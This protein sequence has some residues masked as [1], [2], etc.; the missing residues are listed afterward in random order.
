M[1]REESRL[2]DVAALYVSEIALNWTEE[3]QESANRTLHSFISGQ[4]DFP[5]A[6]AMFQREFHTTV[7][8]ER[9]N[10]ILTVPDMPL[11]SSALCA[12]DG[13]RRKTH[14]WTPPEDIRLLAALHKFGGDNWSRIAKFVGSD[15]TRSQCS[16][17]WQRGLDPRISR[18]HW[19]KEEEDLLVELVAKHGTKSWIAV[20]REMRNRSDVQ[21]R[22]RYMQLHTASP[23][24]PPLLP[25]MPQ[26]PFPRLGEP[27]STTVAN[28][29]DTVLWDNDETLRMK[30]SCSIWQ[31][32][33][34]HSDYRWTID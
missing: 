21:C 6:S 25:P 22:Y 5:T 32:E 19:T 12:T 2:F 27:L 30:T 26:I 17:R 18:S 9:I 20:S 7:P 31:N 28:V 4:I 16:Q 8:V 13:F 29:F 34:G 1:S 10:E 11:P 24:S 33:F 3:M 15:R 23:I 14:Q